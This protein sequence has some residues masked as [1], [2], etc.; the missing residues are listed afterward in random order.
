M[1]NDGRSPRGRMDSEERSRES[2]Q[3]RNYRSD[4]AEKRFAHEGI[5]FVRCDSNT[6]KFIVYGQGRDRFTYF[7]GTGLI[8]G[9]Y[10]SRRGLDAVVSLAKGEDPDGEQAL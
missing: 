3:S 5:Q 4:L 10:K 7:A 6:D 1:G 2:R 9:P 8:L